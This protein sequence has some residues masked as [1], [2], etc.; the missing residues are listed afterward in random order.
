MLENNLWDLNFRDNEGNN[1][2]GNETKRLL[3]RQS[4]RLGKESSKP[5][6]PRRYSRQ[7][8][9]FTIQIR[10]FSRQN[11]PTLRFPNPHF[12]RHP[13]PN[14]QLHRHRRH[15]RP[16][17]N[18][19]RRHRQRPHL[20][21]MPPLPPLLQPTRTHFRSFKILFLPLPFLQFPHL[22]GSST[23]RRK[24]RPLFE[25]KFNFLRLPDRLRRWILFPWRS[26]IREAEFRENCN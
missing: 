8:P 9:S 16:E 10:H 26:R 18:S 19:H 11:P 5:H 21:P 22:F 17:F 12:L 4:N 2:I 23:R 6:H 15:R 1:D 7:F 3:F 13:T 24:L 14:P 20:D 25:S